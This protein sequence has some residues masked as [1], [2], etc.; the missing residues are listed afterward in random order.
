MII[1]DYT[2][3]GS[4]KCVQ[5]FLLSGWRAPWGATCAQS[6]LRP[7][8]ARHP[9]QV[10][11]RDASS[12]SLW[13]AGCC[14][15]CS[16]SPTPACTP[17]LS[18]FS[19]SVPLALTQGWWS[20][21]GGAGLLVGLCLLILLTWL[22]QC[23]CWSGDLGSSH[24]LHPAFQKFSVSFLLVYF[25]TSFCGKM[26]VPFFSPEGGLKPRD[27]GSY[28]SVLYTP[29]GFTSFVCATSSMSL[30]LRDHILL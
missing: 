11:G 23:W 28:S 7:H 16:L 20:K 5:D 3:S 6:A 29:A 19:C 4:L 10:C 9:S 2:F 27:P 26:P 21:V 24:H 22:G 1:A 12:F 8:P 25:C 18:P 15:S 14:S 17:V 30:C 13:G